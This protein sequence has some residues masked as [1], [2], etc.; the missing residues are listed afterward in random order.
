MS[1]LSRC[2]SAALASA[3]ALLVALTIAA[4]G[5]GDDTTTVIESATNE[6]ATDIE[7]ITEEG[8]PQPGDEVVTEEKTPGGGK[9]VEE[10]TVAP[11]KDQGDC[12]PG[13]VEAEGGECLPDQ[14]SG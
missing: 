3:L 11:K 8:A 4:C 14:A 2:H 1:G 6:T 12:A 9:A 10:E 13:E 5:G 7:V